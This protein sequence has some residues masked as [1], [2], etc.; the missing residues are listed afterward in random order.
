M[1][2]KLETISKVLKC[3]TENDGNC[4]LWK[5]I[6]QWSNFF[7]LSLKQSNNVSMTRS[8]YLF[9]RWFIFFCNIVI[10]RQCVYNAVLHINLCVYTKAYCETFKYSKIKKT[11]STISKRKMKNF[12]KNKNT[13]TENK[14]ERYVQVDFRKRYNAHEFFW[15][16][17]SHSNIFHDGFS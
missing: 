14:K 16:L 7:F 10:N 11:H 17:L 6:K 2:V 1:S 5:K 15:N 4:V 8:N 12:S 3:I 9:G 13:F